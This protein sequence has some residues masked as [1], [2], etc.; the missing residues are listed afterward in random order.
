MPKQKGTLKVHPL[1]CG[2]SGPIRVEI[3]AKGQYRGVCVQCGAPVKVE[4]TLDPPPKIGF[5]AP[6]K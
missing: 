1:T 5:Q 4:I 2:H 6:K 3:N